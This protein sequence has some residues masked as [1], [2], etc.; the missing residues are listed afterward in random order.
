MGQTLP[1]VPD[2][3]CMESDLLDLDLDQ[4]VVYAAGYGGL[5]PY[6]EDHTSCRGGMKPRQ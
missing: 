6:L 2:A 4:E 5:Q 1:G 3:V